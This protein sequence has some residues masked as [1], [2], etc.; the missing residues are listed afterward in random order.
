MN[1]I[2]YKYYWDIYTPSSFRLATFLQLP[3]TDTSDGGGHLVREPELVVEAQEKMLKMIGL[4][5]P[6]GGGIGGSNHQWGRLMVFKMHSADYVYVPWK[7]NMHIAMLRHIHL[8]LLSTS[9]FYDYWT[10]SV[11]CMVRCRTTS[12]LSLLS[13]LSVSHTH[14]H[15]CTQV[16]VLYCSKIYCI[17]GSSIIT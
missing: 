4:L 6:E 3:W 9:S 11:D 10:L 12:P 16:W 1:S 2:A 13:S 5:Y 14:T 8:Y 7:H 15:T 17:V